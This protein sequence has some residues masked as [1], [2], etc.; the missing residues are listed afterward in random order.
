MTSTALRSEANAELDRL[1]GRLTRRP[2]TLGTRHR[3]CYRARRH[4]DRSACS[5]VFVGPTR[6]DR[7][8]EK[9]GTR[10][11]GLL[12]RGVWHTPVRAR[13]T[14]SGRAASPWGGCASR[15]RRS[16]SSD[17]I[18]RVE[19]D[20]RTIGIIKR[21]TARTGATAV[22]W[23]P[24]WGPTPPRSP[25]A[26]R[27]SALSRAWSLKGQAGARQCENRGG[28]RVWPGGPL[29]LGATWDGEGVNFALFSEH[30]EGVQLLLFDEETSAVPRPR[31]T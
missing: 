9:R 20:A 31:S 13:S 12:R 21:P 11:D 28:M 26:C 1:R 2:R 6:R 3:H 17:S 29:P 24:S 10:L 25:P 4:L 8:P 16:V 19:S 18:T 14:P 23:Q 22:L 5:S 27:S 15:R 30:A 7:R